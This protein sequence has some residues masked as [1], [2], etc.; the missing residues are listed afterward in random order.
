MAD[1]NNEDMLKAIEA[2]EAAH[3]RQMNAVVSLPNTKLI[4]SHITYA[5]HGIDISFDIER[6]GHKLNVGAAYRHDGGNNVA[7]W[8]SR[9]AVNDEPDT[10]WTQ[11]DTITEWEQLILNWS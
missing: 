1:T 7:Y 10:I 9:D 8:V 6:N 4:Q 5:L 2:I 3:C 11:K